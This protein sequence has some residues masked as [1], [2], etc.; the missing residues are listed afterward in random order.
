MA[1]SPTEDMG[2]CPLLGD[3]QAR[4]LGCGLFLLTPQKSLAGI[5][6]L[7]CH[8]GTRAQGHR[9]PFVHS[10]ALLQGI[11]RMWFFLEGIG[12]T[13]ADETVTLGLVSQ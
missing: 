12:H 6:V 3:L 2:Q 7:G 5:L 1:A 10:K 9:L 8:M 11:K 4:G 13:Q